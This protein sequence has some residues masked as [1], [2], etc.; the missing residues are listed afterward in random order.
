MQIRTLNKIINY[1]FREAVTVTYNPASLR[2][3]VVEV[4]ARMTNDL[5][6]N[7]TFLGGVN[8][9]AANNPLGLGGLRFRE[10]I[11]KSDIS[12][13]RS[14][15]R[16]TGLDK[17]TNLGVYTTQ[18]VEDLIREE[19]FKKLPEVVIPVAGDGHHLPRS[20]WPY[21]RYL[22]DVHSYTDIQAAL[23]TRDASL[24]LDR[25]ARHVLAVIR[26]A[27][28]YVNP[29]AVRQDLPLGQIF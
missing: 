17:A 12:R 3:S 11:V 9:N 10:E 16:R 5:Q 13:I 20:K 29:L 8:W 22:G 25:N 1:S 24:A 14:G 27:A 2:A 7:Y 15:I 6:N 23:D 4:D 19:V 26:S 28:M 18:Q 21:L